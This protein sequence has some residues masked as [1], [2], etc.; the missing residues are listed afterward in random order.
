MKVK[1]VEANKVSLGFLSL[2]FF[3]FLDDVGKAQSKNNDI[4]YA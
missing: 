3:L 4:D 2:S 1:V